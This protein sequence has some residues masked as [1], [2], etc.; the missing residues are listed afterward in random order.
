VM[1]ASDGARGGK[2][3]MKNAACGN[4]EL[5]TQPRTPKPSRKNEAPIMADSGFP[6]WRIGL[7][8]LALSGL[9][10]IPKAP[11]QRH[12]SRWTGAGEGKGRRQK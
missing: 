9:Q 4:D 1:V 7:V 6:N 3:R 5:G 11:G 10:P 2:C 12:L 8:S